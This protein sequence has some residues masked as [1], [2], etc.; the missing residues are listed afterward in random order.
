MQEITEDYLAIGSGAEVA[1]GALFAT[2]EAKNPFDRIVLAIQAAADSTLYVDEDVNILV[3][4]MKKTDK[5]MLAEAFG[6]SLDDLV[7]K[8]KEAEKELSQ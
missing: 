2:K 4:E 5:K 3:T 8:P 7:E 6:I 1:K